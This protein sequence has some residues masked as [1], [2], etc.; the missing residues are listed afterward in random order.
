VAAV[1]SIAKT[2][3]ASHAVRAFAL[4]LLAAVLAAPATGIAEGAPYSLDAEQARVEQAVE[5]VAE[6]SPGATDVFFLGF[7]G[8]GEQGVFR[9]EEEFARRAFAERFGAGNR[10]VELV[11]DEADRR[12]F[13]LATVAN[14]RLALDLIGRKMNRDEDVL[15]LMLT[16]HGSRD[17]IAVTNGDLR[18]AALRP[19]ALRRALDDSGIRWR[20]IVVSA[21]FS[22]VFIK[23]LKTATTLIV[24][25]A[26]ARHSSFGCEDDRELTYFGEAFLRDSLPGAPSIE[27]AFTQALSIVR[28]R[29]ADEGHEHSNPQLYVGAKMRPKLA[30]LENARVQT[31]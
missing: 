30:E 6:H 5:R 11:N 23:P 3:R 22:G 8:Y 9:K 14:L 24:T 10:S 12:T 21:C 15:V 18:L 17:G 16:S 28:R 2:P 7:A 29:E 26:D 25:A 31:D 19:K 20:V 4:A 1:P 27:A 13:P